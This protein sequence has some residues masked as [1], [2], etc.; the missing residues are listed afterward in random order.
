MYISLFCWETDSSSRVNIDT[1]IIL[2][3]TSVSAVGI[4]CM[5]SNSLLRRKPE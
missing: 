4:V 3:P 5:V 1:D 2:F